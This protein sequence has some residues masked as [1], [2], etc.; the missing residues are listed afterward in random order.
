MKIAY[1]SS[2][3]IPSRLAN[4]VHVMKMC[5]GFADNGHEVKLVGIKGD[6]EIDPYDYYNVKGNFEL[7][8][9]QRTNG[10]Q[11]ILKQLILSYK[12]SR[13]SDLIY[14]RWRIGALVLRVLTNK[15]I[16][17]EY[18]NSTT[19][20]KN[21]IIQN[22]FIKSK[23]VR[24]V[25]ITQSLK[26]HYLKTYSILNKRETLVLPD[27]ADAISAYDINIY[28][29]N[30]KLECGYLGSF[31]P[32]K[33]V[34]KVVEVA[35]QM[36]DVI[37]HI[38]GGAKNEISNLQ[39]H[40]SENV[41]LH[42]HLPQKEAIDILKG[43]DITLLPNQPT[44]LVKNGQAD[45]GKWTSPM[46]LFEY[47]ALEKVIIASDLPVLKEILEHERNSLLVDH[48]DIEQWIGAIERVREE[49]ELKERLSLNARLDLENFYTWKVRSNKSLENLLEI[50]KNS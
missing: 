30:K 15:H 17:F 36:P 9:V 42:G 19:G 49:K 39:K 11:R 8:L 2:S 24:H 14:T 37:F 20:I 3:V 31:M 13:D 40:C 32:G 16:I 25:F 33:G 44:V 50:S 34:E 45:I 10:L 4:S 29:K 48:D 5:Q 12:I 6:K 18:H 35:K 7:K 47:M 1:I 27:G 21:K 46:K 43:I 22:L 28:K 23:R 26:E 41:I 38:I